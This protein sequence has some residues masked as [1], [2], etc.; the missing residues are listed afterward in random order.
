M[1]TPDASRRLRLAI[2]TATDEETCTVVA[3]GERV[4]VKYAA[5]FPRPRVERVAPGQLVAIAP[6]ADGHDRLVWRWFDAVVLERTEGGFRVWEP[7][8]G[9][10]LA[11]PR[12][13]AASPEPG[14]R[15]YAS[16]GLPGADWWLSGPAVPSAGLADVEVDEVVRFL[17]DNGLWSRLD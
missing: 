9:E 7:G 1:S 10:V 6:G 11:R 15:A 16:A 17:D 14:S 2:V 5:F 12:D 13:V 3:N 8:H 4:E